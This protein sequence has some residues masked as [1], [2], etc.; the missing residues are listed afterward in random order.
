MKTTFLC[1]N[2]GS[3][4]FFVFRPVGRDVAPSGAAGILL[5][6]SWGFTASRAV[7][8]KP[9]PWFVR[10]FTDRRRWLSAVTAQAAAALA[11]LVAA[12]ARRLHGGAGLWSSVPQ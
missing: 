4:R 7:L 9:N 10:L 5:S 3:E 8:P 2:S 12:A 11:W 1:I 6:G